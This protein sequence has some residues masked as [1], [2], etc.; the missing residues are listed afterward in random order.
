MKKFLK[1]FIIILLVLAVVGGTVFFFFKKHKQENTETGS[2][3]NFVCS[4]S[5]V[6]LSDKLLVIDR[7]IVEGQ[8]V[9]VGII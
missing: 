6:K 8:L 3:I 7:D 5:K 9:G 1:V 2:I 4:E